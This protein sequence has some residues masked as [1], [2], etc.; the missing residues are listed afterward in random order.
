[1]EEL[2]TDV[3][4]KGWIQMLLMEELDTD[5][6]WKGWKGLR[7]EGLEGALLGSGRR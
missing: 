4:W 1:M 6:G 2:D 3:N 7:I 5:V